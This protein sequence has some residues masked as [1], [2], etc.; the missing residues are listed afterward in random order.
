MSIFDSKLNAKNL[1]LA[2]FNFTIV[3]SLLAIAKYYWARIVTI[4]VLQIITKLT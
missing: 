4:N 2:A 1:Q 3:L